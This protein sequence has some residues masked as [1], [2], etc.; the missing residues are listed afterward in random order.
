MW[1]SDIFRIL[2][3]FDKNNVLILTNGFRK[4]TQKTPSSEIERAEKYKIEYLWRNQK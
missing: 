4:K 2:G 3:V 1:Q